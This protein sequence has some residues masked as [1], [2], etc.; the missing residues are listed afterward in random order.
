MTVARAASAGLW[1][2]IDVLLRQGTQFVVSIILARLLSP[3]DFGIV[4]ITTFFSTLAQVF[5][6]GG[7]TSALIQQQSTSHAQ[8]SSAFWLNLAASLLF[9]LVLVL[10][11]PLVAS[12]YRNRLLQPLIWVSAAQVVVSALGA[13]QYALLN[14][15]LGFAAIAKAGIFSAL[16]SGAAGLCA[17]WAGAG[18]WALAILSATATASYTA[19]MWAV[20]DWRP[21]FVLSFAETLPLLAFGAWLSLSSVLEVFFTQ[22]FSLLLGK[23]HGVRDLGLYN[24]ASNTQQLPSTIFSVI[25]ARVALPLFA[26][27]ANDREGTLRGFKMATGFLMLLHVPV[28]VGLMLVPGQ[29]IETLFGAKWLPAA[30]ILAI[31]ALGGILYPLHVMNL[32]VLIAQGQSRLFFRIE[33]LKKTAGITCVLIGSVFGIEGLAWSQVAASV[34]AMVLNS[35]PTR[36]SLGYSGWRQ[37]WDLRGIF[38]C[39]GVMAGVS[40][41]AQWMMRGYAPQIQLLVVVP[42]AALAYGAAALMGRLRSLLDALAILRTLFLSRRV[43]TGGG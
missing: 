28:M 36:R 41:L 39:A 26:P 31:L 14:R 6:Q 12:F 11:A 1:S 32:Q 5:I 22:G 16:L 13:V 15:D 10:A 35:N 38:A 34:I 42:V 30:P 8:Q 33:I 17:A 40:V 21:R 9:A 43:A 25:I 27:R 20:S 18:V 4:A 19:A 7:L 29:I 3:A 2:T 23:L 37:L 24:R